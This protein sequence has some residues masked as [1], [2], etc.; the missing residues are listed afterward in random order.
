MEPK[1]PRTTRTNLKKIH[2]GK[3]IKES[4]IGYVS[5]QMEPIQLVI[6]NLQ[7]NIFTFVL[8][9]LP[10]ISI[11]ARFSRE[12]AFIYNKIIQIVYH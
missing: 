11:S 9:Q 1:C 5:D 7:R 3:K 2:G 4:S 8:A 6:M 10:L 12:V